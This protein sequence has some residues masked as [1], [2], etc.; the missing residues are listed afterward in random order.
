VIKAIEEA[1]AH[2]DLSENAEYVAADLLA[3]AEHGS[4]HERVW[5]VTTSGKLLRAV[6][7]E[8]KARRKRQLD[9]RQI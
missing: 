7:K 1:R 5:L 2:G 9:W 3:Q 8:A 6:E 4:G